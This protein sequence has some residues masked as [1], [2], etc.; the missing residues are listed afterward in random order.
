MNFHNFINILSDHTLEISR[1]NINLTNINININVNI[2]FIVNKIFIQSNTNDLVMK[3]IYCV[4]REK[5][6]TDVFEILVLCS[7]TNLTI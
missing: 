2:K 4:Q 3:C 1:V 7:K 5:D 6:R